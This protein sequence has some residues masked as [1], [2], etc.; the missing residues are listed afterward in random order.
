MTINIPVRVEG[1]VNIDGGPIRKTNRFFLAL[2][3]Y[4]HC[5]DKGKVV[6][7]IECSAEKLKA[8]PDRPL[9]LMASLLEELLPCMLYSSPEAAAQDLEEFK[10]FVSNITMGVTD[11]RVEGR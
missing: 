2:R 10:Q 9:A 5:D 6:M 4:G 1:V 7:G 3:S 8:P 11:E